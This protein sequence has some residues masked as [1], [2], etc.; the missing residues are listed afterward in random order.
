LGDAVNNFFSNCLIALFILIAGCLL[1]LAFAPFGFYPF[2]VI[3]PAILLFAWLK[4]SA[5]QAFWL[6]YLFGIGFFTIG[7]S[8][9][10]ISIHEYGGAGVMLAGLIIGLM[11]LFLA[12]FPALQGYLLTRFFKNNSTKICLAF[13]SSWVLLEWIRS[14]IFTGL[15]WLLLGTSQTSSWLKGF[16]PLVGEYGVSFLVVLSSGLLVLVFNKKILFSIITLLIIWC[17]G[18]TLTKINWTQAQGQPIKVALVQGDI[19]EQEKWTPEY[20]ISTLQRYYQF[21]QQHWDASLIVWPETAIP[22]LQTQAH[23]FITLLQAQAKQHHVALITGIPIEEGFTDY[24]AMIVVGEGEGTYY[25]RHLVPFGEYVPLLQWLGGLLN[26]LD[27]PMSSFTAGPLDHAP[28]H[29]HNFIVAPFIC[30]EV[31]YEPI[32]LHELPQANVLVTISNDAWF[33]HSFAS[34][35]HL[36]IGQFRALETGRYHLFTTNSGVTAI[37][38]AHGVIQNRAPVF[39]STVLTGTIQMMQGTTPIVWL[40]IIPIIVLMGLLFVIALIKR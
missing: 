1:P 32:V 26:V 15:P 17:S 7:V 14:W 16:A 3:C 31:A 8:W 13:P 12:L 25:K 21:T 30:Y 29:V 36:Q 4:C 33:G 40:G 23:D 18:F 38:D 10:F 27:M 22:M 35:Q 34:A 28:L 20:L 24:N 2:A 39:T 37:I 6:G 19:P 5:K 9:M 11:I